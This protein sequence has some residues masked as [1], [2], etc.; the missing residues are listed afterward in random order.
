MQPRFFL[1]FLFSSLLLAGGW[2]SR[3]S[4]RRAKRPVIT[5][6]AQ[7]QGASSFVTEAGKGNPAK[8][9]ARLCWTKKCR[10]PTTHLNSSRGIY[11]NLPPTPPIGW[12]SPRERKM[13]LWRGVGRCEAWKFICTVAMQ[14]PLCA[15]HRVQPAPTP[16]AAVP[17]CT[18]TIW[19]VPFGP[20]YGQ[21]R[22]LVD[23]LQINR[24]LHHD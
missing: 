5:G 4:R 13:G 15:A 6:W 12:P 24:F 19:A 10:D 14:L 9:R 7:A 20:K 8:P 23:P 1:S 17:P 3:L 16:C 18:G 21:H 22:R 11:P 2:V